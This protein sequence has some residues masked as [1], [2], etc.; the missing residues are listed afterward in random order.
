VIAIGV[1]LDKPAVDPERHIAVLNRDFQGARLFETINEQHVGIC[2]PQAEERNGHEK[3]SKRAT[4]RQTC[5]TS[6][7]T[8]SMTDLQ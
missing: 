7:T 2:Q 4:I 8:R 1:S 5:A 6:A 3:K